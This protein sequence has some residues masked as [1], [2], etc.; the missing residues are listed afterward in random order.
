MIYIRYLQ[1]DGSQIMAEG[2]FISALLMKGQS[3]ELL[4]VL[5]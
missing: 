3:R 2:V 4:V 1:E 5:A